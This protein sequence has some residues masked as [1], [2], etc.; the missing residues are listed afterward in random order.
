MLIQW[1][2]S[3]PLTGRLVAALAACTLAGGVAALCADRAL[4]SSD[5]GRA[6]ALLTGLLA[7]A[8]AGGVGLLL[9]RSI[10]QPLR[11]LAG[12][13][14]QLAGGDLS[15]P[16]QDA[17]HDEVAAIAR[18]LAECSERISLTLAHAGLAAADVSSGVNEISAASQMLGDRSLR[19]ARSLEQTHTVLDELTQ[20]I[21][22]NATEAERA[23]LA[24]DPVTEV[25][26]GG[27]DKLD[28]AVRAMRDIEANARTIAQ[29]VTVIDSIAFQTNILSLNATIEAARAGAAGRGFSVVASAVR[30]LATRSAEAAGK[31]RLLSET[32]LQSVT[33]GSRMVEEAGQT[34]REMVDGV[35]TLSPIV[36]G[37]YWGANQQAQGIKQVLM[38]V[39]EVD[40]ATSSD[41][42]MAEQLSATTAELNSGAQDLVARLA[43][44]RLAERAA[45]R[46][47]RDRSASPVP[48]AAP[49]IAEAAVRTAD[50][51]EVQFF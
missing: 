15:R 43:V 5:P 45:D 36:S 47:L 42:G 10:A 31:I 2:R 32:T 30:E 7:L 51:S 25:A 27:Q 28:R 48:R 14:Q 37:F 44:F 19:T 12:H 50:T 21:T 29:T 16:L 17:G 41:A 26:T 13:V 1:T 38:T 40:A 3:L 24:M 20:N 34:L 39:A 33:A 49:R 4:G 46:A 11:A 22:R 8:V 9:V 6:A 18:S 35:T 23:K